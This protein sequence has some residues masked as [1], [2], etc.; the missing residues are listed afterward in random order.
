MRILY[1]AAWALL[2]AGVLPAQRPAPK[3]KSK[4]QPVLDPN[5][6]V[7]GARYPSLTPD[8]KTVVFGLHGDIWS[9]AASGGRATR[10]TLNDSYETRP[11]VTPDG[12][13]VVFISDRNGSYDIFR[14]PID[15]GPP[16]RLTYHAS[17]DVPTGFTADGKNLL[18]YSSRKMN[19]NR[20]GV[21]DVYSIPLIGGTPTRLT[22]TGGRDACTTDDGSNL[23]YVDGSSDAKVQEYRGTANDRL[24]A[25]QPGSAP[26]EILHWNGNSRDP[27]VLDGGKSLV[28]IREI[29][30]SFE[31][32]KSNLT[33]GQ[34]TQLT[35]LGS[36]GAS[37]MRLT[38]DGKTALFTWKFYLHSLDLTKANANPKLLKVKI[39]EDTRGDK[40]VDRT[41]TRGI[42]RAH[43]NSHGIVFSLSGDIWR[44]GTG[45]GTA[46]QI[47]N[48]VHVNENPKLSPDGRSISFYSN[49]SG[50]SD[51]WIIGTNGQGL[52]QVTT[53]M[54]DEF[55]QDWSP[56]GTKVVFCSTRSGTKN[57]W[58]KGINGEAAV[59][60][61]KDKS[62]NDDP[63]FS[64]DGTKIAFD[65]ARTGNADIYVMDADGSNQR[66]V[67]GTPSIEEVP[68]WSPDGRF[69]AFDKITRGSSFMR[70]EVV[71]TDL[72]GSGEVLVGTGA[73]ASYSGDGDHIMYVDRNGELA[74]A[75]APTGITNGRNI[76]FLAVRRVSEKAE[77]LRAFDEAHESFKNRFYDPNF[78]GK[79]WNALGR[80]YRALVQSCDTRE[81]FLYYLNRMVGEVSASHTGANARTIKAKPFNT[82]DLGMTMVPEAFQGPRQRLKI[83]NVEKDGAADKAWIRKGDYIFRVNGQP[84]MRGDNVYRHLE[85]ANGKE[86]ALIVAD[87]ARGQNFRE[88]KV[89]PESLTQR[90]QR[91]YRQ[92]LRTCSQTTTMKSRGQVAYLH[93]PAMN[94]QALTR[95]QN[96]LA[97]PMVQ[98]AKALV[99]DVRDNGGGNIHQQLVDILSRRPY[100]YMQMRDGRRIGQPQMHW[101]RPIAVLINERSYSD[102]EVF[103]HAM[104]TL[105]MA[106]IIGIQ[107][108]G[109]VIGTNNITLSDGTS[110]RLPGSGFFNHDGTNQ[111]HNG[112]HPD[113]EVGITPAELLQGKD[114]QLDTAVNHLLK[115]IAGGAVKPN[116]IPTTP[117]TPAKEGEFI[118]PAALPM[119][120]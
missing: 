15:G 68:V 111:E 94:G 44:M 114:T 24:F 34:T 56:D 59:Q 113:I 9:M 53:D 88:V 63:V 4:A 60:L 57:I 117:G 26:V 61:T 13:E 39:I 14:M 112:C 120:E 38:D 17:G 62:G 69:L 100:A 107:T 66:R 16:T 8:G 29:K 81:E 54:A 28:F 32:F 108:P 72:A 70:Q 77:M 79:D 19:W 51:I 118:E 18:F 90:R 67:Y 86:V 64:P 48:D 33:T 35:N 119:D 101:N 103:P 75:P 87:N 40:L 98:R 1:V 45:G 99:I 96:E 106:T 80:Q 31:I 52:R 5:L 49:R 92:Y 50:N 30:G 105:G 71:V 104:K 93:I 85:N 12:K 84:I 91:T 10:L 43:M 25:A 73:Y 37:T 6:G 116:P 36:D 95:F 21:Y 11:Y 46:I 74:Y 27:H 65:S 89:K 23:W 110:W 76:P 97:S 102:A 78:H 82:G 22:F 47:T 55:F 83:T 3:T 58:V 20:G 115:Q 7:P 41:F 109:A 42:S 2:F